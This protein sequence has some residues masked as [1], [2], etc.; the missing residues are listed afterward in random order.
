[1]QLI[2]IYIYIYIY[3]EAMNFWNSNLGYVTLEIIKW[4]NFGLV[5]MMG[6]KSF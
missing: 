5:F 4:M 1:M 6:L 3:I 2:D